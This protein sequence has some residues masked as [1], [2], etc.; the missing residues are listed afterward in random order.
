MHVLVDVAMGQYRCGV[1]LANCWEIKPII[2]I[3]LMI[4]RKEEPREN[5]SHQAKLEAGV[6]LRVGYH[7]LVDV[8]RSISLP[9]DYT[10]LGARMR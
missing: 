5:L 4:Y 8:P 6:N 2:D 1:S 3:Q 9:R 7:K 10:R